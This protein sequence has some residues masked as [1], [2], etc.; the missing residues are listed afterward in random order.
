VL[1]SIWGYGTLRPVQEQV[2][3]EVMAGRDVLA[4]LP[5]GGGKS[6]CYQVPALAMGRMGLVISPLIALMKDQVEG[7][8]RRGVRARAITSELSRHEI[9][10]VLDNAL[11]GKVDLLYVAPE[12]LG[13]ELFEARLPRLPIGLIAVD[14]AHCISQWGYD[15]RPA[16][17]RIARVREVLPKVPV[18]ALTASATPQVAADIREKLALR[19]DAPV[20][21]PFHRPELVLWVDH[22]EDRLGRLVKL[23]QRSKGSAIVYLRDRRGT[24]RV[25]ETLRREG[26]SAAAYHAGMPFEERD[27]V[28]QAWMRDEVRVVAATNAFGMGIDKPDVRLVVHLEPPP[29]LESFYQEAGRAGRDGQRSHAVLIAQAGDAARLREKVAASFPPITDVRKVY[30]SFA[31]MNRIALGAGALES[32]P[33]DLRGIA[34]RTKLPIASVSHA[35]KALELDGALALSDGLRTPSRV[36]IRADHRV[37]HRLRLENNRLGPVLECLLRLHGGLFE[38]AAVIEEG[39]I[40]AQLKWSVTTV[41]GAL[42]ELQDQGVIVYRPR[43]DA[44]TATLL[45]PRR[46]A[47]VLMLDPASLDDRRTRALQRLEAMLAFT[48]GTQRCRTRLLLEHFGETMDADCGTCDRCVARARTTDPPP[49]TADP[50]AEARSRWEMDEHP[51]GA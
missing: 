39:R 15:F 25:A 51:D 23:M 24:A 22:S 46:D 2:I 1:S 49:G 19:I 18:I 47:A 4:L 35:M 31:D 38:E 13:S 9:D 41:Q 21:G 26:I 7:L 3:A 40:A 32:Y 14:E 30:Q 29:D 50:E 34:A 44:P 37:V 33:V 17:Q 10:L 28:Q 36:F 45:V 48:F 16:Y 8:R 11:A 43:S 5:T 42:K 20:R 6:L 27:R 12:R